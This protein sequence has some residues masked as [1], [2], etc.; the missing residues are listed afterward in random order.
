[1]HFEKVTVG[2]DKEGAIELLKLPPSF[3]VMPAEFN[4]LRTSLTNVV[5]ISVHRQSSRSTSGKWVVKNI[6]LKFFYRNSQQIT[7]ITTLEDDD[8]LSFV[9]KNKEN[10]ELC[11]AENDEKEENRD[12]TCC[13][14]GSYL[15]VCGGVGGFSP[16]YV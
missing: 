16:T 10:E 12:I 14:C 6:P 7:V 13:F 2:K 9:I 4:L 8:E 3:F 1:M 5:N 11:K 15:P